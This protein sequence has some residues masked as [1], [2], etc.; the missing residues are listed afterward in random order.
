MKGFIKEDSTIFNVQ[1]NVKG[2]QKGEQ[3]TVPPNTVGELLDANRDNS[4]A[5]Q[6]KPYPLDKFD[7]ISSEIFISVLNLRKIVE[8]ASCN[9]VVTKKYSSVLKDVMQ[10]I[11]IIGSNLV[12]IS[13]IV[14]KIK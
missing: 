6:L 7:D 2:I 13:K 11:D 14:D 10:K 3:E 12:E 9:P 4:T 5:P 8:T 1:R